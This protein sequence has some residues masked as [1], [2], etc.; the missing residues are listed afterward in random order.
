MTNYETA[1]DELTEYGILTDYP[2]VT[3][4]DYRD[5]HGEPR[6]ET[7]E[8]VIFED[9]HGYELNEWAD[10]LEMDRS[11]LAGRMHELARE[12]EPNDGLDHWAAADPVVFDART[13]E[14]DEDQ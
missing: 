1:T 10:V 11:E 13:F 4:I 5:L 7:D 9:G 14:E 6:H 3:M 2:D 8:Q 12:H